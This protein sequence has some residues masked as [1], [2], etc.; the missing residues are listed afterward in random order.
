M[1]LN[2]EAV[3]QVFGPETCEYDQDDVILYALGIGAE[4]NELQFLYENGLQVLPTFAVIP[5]RFGKLNPFA[6]LK[7]D[8][9]KVLHGENRIEVPKPL[10][11]KAKL[12]ATA[13]IKA[14]YDKGKGAVV[15]TE[16]EAK[17]EKGELV[18][19]NIASIF[20]RGEGNFGGD[21]GPSGAKNEPPSRPPDAVIAMKTR[22]NQAQLY[23][24]SGD[25]NPLHVDP[26][27]AKLAGFDTPILHGLC[28]YGHCARA[29]MKAFCD[30]KPEKI[31][32]FEVRFSG[33][34][35]PGETITTEMWKEGDNKVIFRAFTKE[36]NYVISNAAAELG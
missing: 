19:K 22:D 11:V 32:A 33:V 23:R 30:N 24:L 18:F 29:V 5:V 3:G 12:S 6:T 14:V 36:G 31:K 27:F 15:V 35:Y 10:P 2:L 28:T 25:K 26:R 8:L 17:D 1:A 20:V 13:T 7:V 9:M 4:T 16:T 21:R 34:V